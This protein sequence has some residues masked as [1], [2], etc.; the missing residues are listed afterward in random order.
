MKDTC[1]L[2]STGNWFVMCFMRFIC[3]ILHVGFLI[4]AEEWAVGSYIIIRTQDS[5]KRMLNRLIIQQFPIVS[6]CNWHILRYE[7]EKKKVFKL[8]AESRWAVW[9]TVTG[10]CMQRLNGSVTFI[11]F[12]QPKVGYIFKKLR[13]ID[14]IHVGTT[15]TINGTSLFSLNSSYTWYHCLCVVWVLL[16]DRGSILRLRRV[17]KNQEPMYS[18]N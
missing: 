18:P 14:R 1:L 8:F 3:F 16:T 7:Q 4:S 9:S 12:S 5:F 11:P 15:G 13:V 17:I 6:S 2:L 10:V